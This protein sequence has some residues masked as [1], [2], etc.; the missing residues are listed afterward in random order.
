MKRYI[1]YILL[2]FVMGCSSEPSGKV[3]AADAIDV[4][5]KTESSFPGTSTAEA[6]TGLLNMMK[7]KGA[8][9][10]VIG[11]SQEYKSGGT[12]DVFFKVKLNGE[13]SVFQWQI[14]P[15][16]LVIPTNTLALNV[17]KAIASK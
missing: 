13:L 4:I 8:A 7:N 6:I 2:I 14:K 1:V 15:D 12:H 9:V 3:N 16:G 10:D 11:W 17:T 5:K